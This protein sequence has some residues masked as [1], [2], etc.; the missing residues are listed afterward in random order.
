LL[1][2]RQ[3]LCGLLLVG[4]AL[5]LVGVVPVG[6]LARRPAIADGLAAAARLHPGVCFVDALDTP[7]S[8]GRA[9]LDVDG[10]D[11]AAFGLLCLFAGRPLCYASCP[12]GDLFCFLSGELVGLL[13]LPLDGTCTAGLDAAVVLLHE[14]GK[15]RRMSERTPKN[16][17]PVTDNL[18]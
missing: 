2:V 18:A 9:L 17:L 16:I 14:E 11:H 7:A 12:S 13:V 4:H 15:K 1:E 6:K 5:V 8:L 3:R 10:A